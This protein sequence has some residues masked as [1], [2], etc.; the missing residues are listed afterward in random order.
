[1]MFL[2]EDWFPGKPGPNNLEFY[3]RL[4]DS[5]ASF[6][7]LE[8]TTEDLR[9]ELEHDPTTIFRLLYPDVP[10]LAFERGLERVLDP[11]NLFL[12]VFDVEANDNPHA[13]VR[14][15]VYDL[16]SGTSLP[17][18]FLSGRRERLVAPP[19]QQQQG[20]AVRWFQVGLHMSR[21]LA[22]VDPFR[23]R[24]TLDLLRSSHKETPQGDAEEEE[25]RRRERLFARRDDPLELQWRERRRE[26]EGAGDWFDYTHVGEG[27]DKVNNNSFTL[28]HLRARLQRVDSW[29]H[30][31]TQG[32]TPSLVA[33]TIVA[34]AFDPVYPVR[35]AEG[36]ET[37]MRLLTA[38]RHIDEG[39]RVAEEEEQVV[40]DMAFIDSVVQL[41]PKATSHGRR[42][43]IIGA[44]H[45]LNVHPDARLSLVVAAAQLVGRLNIAIVTHGDRFLAVL[46]SSTESND[47]R[48]IPECWDELE[49]PPELF[50]AIEGSRR[51]RTPT[52]VPA[53][54]R[55]MADDAC[56]WWTPRNETSEGLIEE[57]QAHDVRV[58][59][60]PL[61]F[62][63]AERVSN[64][65]RYNLSL[66]LEIPNLIP[67][68]D[69]AFGVWT[70][71][72]PGLSAWLERLAQLQPNS[73][74]PDCALYKTWCL[75]TVIK[76][77][78]KDPDDRLLNEI[79]R[80]EQPELTR[81]VLRIPQ[82]V[83]SP[84]QR[85]ADES[86]MEGRDA[87]ENQWL[88][89][90]LAR[91]TTFPWGFE[92]R[93]NQLLP[94]PEERQQPQQSPLW[95]QQDFYQLLHQHHQQ[96]PR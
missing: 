60:Y 89:E 64:F 82:N 11:S 92:Q 33:A 90:R 22:T 58:T 76:N 95:H 13:D 78:E 25:R 91:K 3:V 53:A 55:H 66:E 26:L 84:Q 20:G 65:D 88:A 23:I 77:W 40:S 38:I 9:H 59:E 67:I 35:L 18:P 50:S 70:L 79:V 81:E 49:P 43:F 28:E 44:A 80:V 19:P 68:V 69:V 10:P 15:I 52:F 21:P 75:V 4:P 24:R 63:R 71:P 27:E 46:K 86:W 32:E 45:N 17:D 87:D 57:A 16:A 56:C 39:L 7:L 47:R 61:E 51:H 6:Y 72:A 54:R 42:N 34:A 29:I 37:W 1:M 62:P 74:F 94:L 12:R 31:W 5:H 73:P 8:P 48:R 96:H 2:V 30:W 93:W 85:M 83:F 14:V 36:V 41:L